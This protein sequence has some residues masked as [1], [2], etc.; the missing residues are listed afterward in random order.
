ME[1]IRLLLDFLV[2]IKLKCHNKQ[3]YSVVAANLRHPLK[4]GFLIKLSN[5]LQV[6]AFLMPNK[7][8]NPQLMF[9]DHYRLGQELVVCSV[10]KLH[11]LALVYLASNK[12]HNRQLVVFLVIS[13]NRPL[14]LPLD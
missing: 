7:L 9:L 10:I 1:I 14:K 13:S 2:R 4:V 11:L 3:D 12:H 6:A 8:L 5:N